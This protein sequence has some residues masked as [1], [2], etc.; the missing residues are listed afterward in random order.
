[1]RF[2]TKKSVALVGGVGA[3]VFFLWWAGRVTYDTPPRQAPRPPTSA[4]FENLKSPTSDPNALREAFPA[5][6]PLLMGPLAG[7]R[8]PEIRDRLYQCREGSLLNANERKAFDEAWKGGPEG[9]RRWLEKQPP[10]ESTECLF[11]AFASEWGAKAGSEAWAWAQASGSDALSLAVLAGMAGAG[12]EEAGK[13]GATLP[14]HGER[15]EERSVWVFEVLQD[16]GNP[17]A[18]L[19]FA[20][21]LDEPQRSDLLPQ[22][23]ASLATV[24]PADA[25]KEAIA[26]PEG[27]QREALLVT[28]VNRWPAHQMTALDKLLPT[29]KDENLRYQASFRLGTLRGLPPDRRRDSEH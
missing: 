12:R 11:L 29:L 17:A 19:R 5:I 6:P 16:A 8:F 20:G 26:L 7:T 2:I 21:A 10:S 27:P 22:A 13:L 4:A 1:M 15:S 28:I 24:A 23:L 14:G 9:V 25:M 3:L 18:Q